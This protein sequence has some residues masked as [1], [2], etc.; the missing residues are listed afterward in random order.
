M[1]QDRRGYFIRADYWY[2]IAG[3]GMGESVARLWLGRRDRTINSTL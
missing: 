2:S 3:L 1:P